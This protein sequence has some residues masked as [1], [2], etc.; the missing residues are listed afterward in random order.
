[1]TSFSTFIFL[2]F[3]P[4]D[5]WGPW[6]N[7]WAYEFTGRWVHNNGV[8]YEFHTSDFNVPVQIHYNVYQQNSA[9]PDA[10]V[11]AAGK[12]NNITSSYFNI[13]IRMIG[14]NYDYSYSNNNIINF[15]DF[16]SLIGFDQSDDFADPSSDASQNHL[17]ITHHHFFDD[18]YTQSTNTY[19]YAYYYS[20]HLIQGDMVINNYKDFDLISSQSSATDSKYD[21]TSVAAHEFG[22]LAGLRH[23]WDGEVMC[24][25]VTQ[26]ASELFI[27]SSDESYINFLY[28][29]CDV[30]NSS[31][32][33][34]SRFMP[35]AQL[36][37]AEIPPV[38]DGCWGDCCENRPAVTGV[39]NEALKNIIHFSSKCYWNIN[40][41][42]NNIAQNHEKLEE[43]ADTISPDPGYKKAQVLM[44]DCININAPLIDAS[45]RCELNVIEKDLKL[46]SKH[47]DAFINVIN[48][49]LTLDI[50]DGLK[51]ELN[52]LKSQLPS[53]EGKNIKE[54]ILLYDA[55]LRGA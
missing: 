43:I 1:M 46:T 20:P 47:I 9:F 44:S 10:I 11:N 53:Y 15:S 4:C 16:V 25:S 39:S 50:S 3:C 49:F 52:F 7:G 5:D 26:G 54:A 30:G 8:A 45:F 23:N 35:G 40:R 32:V 27:N 55:V 28:C 48:E 24:E 42:R 38:E 13:S 14:S 17:A 37:I 41:L 12:W 6:V 18:E 22:H 36:L 29:G 34:Y 33:P 19:T 21:F 51:T 31:Y 2:S